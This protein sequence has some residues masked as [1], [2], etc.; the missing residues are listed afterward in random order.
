ML[1]RLQQVAALD[2]Q[3]GGDVKDKCRNGAPLQ[4]AGLQHPTAPQSFGHGRLD[5][6]AGN[7]QQ[8]C[9]Q[10]DEVKALPG[11]PASDGID[12]DQK[13]HAHDTG[14]QKT[15]HQET[16]DQFPPRRSGEA[17]IAQRPLLVKAQPQPQT[18]QNGERGE[19]RHGNIL[20]API[21]G[22][23]QPE[24]AGNPAG[25]PH[26]DIDEQPHQRRGQ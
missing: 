6:G 17:D 25:D 11:A 8:G 14:D 18:A 7:D 12:A 15:S 2:D 5:K 20:P 21:H 3:P 10:P 24:Q 19:Q 13:A 1:G 22:G 23:I 16:A 26:T 4:R 9:G